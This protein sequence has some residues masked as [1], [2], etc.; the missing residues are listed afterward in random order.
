MLLGSTKVN[1]T[2]KGY[3]ENFRGTEVEP[4]LDAYLEGRPDDAKSKEVSKAFA[5]AVAAFEPKTDIQKEAKDFILANTD[6]L[7]KRSY[8][9]FGGDG[10]AYDIGYG[11][12]D[13]VL[14]SG[15]NINC[16]V[17]DTEVY[18][19]T[20]GQ[21]S[22]STAAGAVA[23]FAAD[24]KKTKKKDLGMMA[25][26]YGYVYVAQVAMG[27]DPEQTLKAIRE[28]EEYDG[29][30][31]IICYCPCIEHGPKC[32]MGKSQLEEKAAVEAGY[33]HCY[34]YDPRRKEQGLNPFQLDSKEPTGD[35]KTFLRG[36]NRYASLE[37]TF[38]EIAKELFEKAERDAKE[39][40]DSYKKLA[41]G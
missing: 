30:S 22:K 36:E 19:N 2:I 26:S 35:L 1:E 15:K 4:A 12:L 24:G 11:G 9:A 3:A 8:W 16:L 40:L 21:S 6:Y 14:A 20:G 39:R 29:P 41:E 17:L 23:K 13:H 25:M 18:S 37:I 34:R 28:A 33:W 27:Y 31:L 38:P 5:D 10:W 32:G 7:R